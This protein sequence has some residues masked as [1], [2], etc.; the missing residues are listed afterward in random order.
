[1]YLLNKEDMADPEITKRMGALLES[2]ASIRCPFP[3]R[4][5][6]PDIFKAKLKIWAAASGESGRKGYP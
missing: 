4:R 6:I 3:Q 2:G 5:E 1:M